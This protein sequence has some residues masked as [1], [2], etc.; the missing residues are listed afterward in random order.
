MPILAPTPGR[1]GSNQNG[2]FRYDGQDYLIKPSRHG[3]LRDMPWQIFEKLPN[4]ITCFV[5][6]KPEQFLA[7]K[8]VFPF[9]FQAKYRIRVTHQCLH[10]KIKIRNG[11][12]NKQPIG[13]GWHP[14]LHRS[15]PCTVYIPARLRWELDHAE[16]PTPTGILKQVS[17]KDDFRY[18]RFLDREEHWDDVFTG[19]VSNNRIVSCYIDEQTEILTK[20]GQ[21]SGF[22][23]RSV[24]LLH[25]TICHGS[26]PMRH[27]QLFTPKGRNAICLEPLSSPPNAINLL[28]QAHPRSDVCEIAPGEEASFQM[29]VRFDFKTL[30][31]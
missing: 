4:A 2:T 6:I 30:P 13:V 22:V 1:V 29:D 17:G 15:G 26:V 7:T 9:D 21:R 25:D 16:E 10:C 18:G 14:Y 23:R 19:L 8:G 27:M 24:N 11:G 5:S 28:A 20:T 31:P 3:F 12:D